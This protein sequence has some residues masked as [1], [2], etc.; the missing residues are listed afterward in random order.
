[1]CH[2]KYDINMN[3]GY[4]Y[5]AVGLVVNCKIIKSEIVPVVQILRDQVCSPV[6]KHYQ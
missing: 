1:M 5:T 2:A 3:I 6:T 4:G